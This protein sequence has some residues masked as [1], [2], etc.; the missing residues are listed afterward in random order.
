MSVGPY[1]LSPITCPIMEGEG[2]DH[3]RPI[4]QRTIC[5][6]A[7][8]SCALDIGR[9]STSLGQRSLSLCLMLR[10]GPLELTLSTIG[11][12]R[13]MARKY[14]GLIALIAHTLPTCVAG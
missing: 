6:Q 2:T 9:L 7:I 14:I 13:A 8:P 12:F 11:N 5:P 10:F 4:S 1:E 3:G